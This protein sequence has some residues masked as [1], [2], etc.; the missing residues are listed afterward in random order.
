VCNFT[1]CI[2][3]RTPLYLFKFQKWE[4]YAAIDLKTNKIKTGNS[5]DKSIHLYSLLNSE[6]IFHNQY[7]DPVVK[8]DIFAETFQVPIFSTGP[9]KN[10]FDL[11]PRKNFEQVF[12]E[13]KLLWPIPIFTRYN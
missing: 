5:I 10:G 12:G 7:I 11:G 8:V 2:F 4:K 9:D 6:G 13:K 3:L 1:L